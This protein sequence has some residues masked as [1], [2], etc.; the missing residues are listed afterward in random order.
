M[1]VLAVYQSRHF[2]WY[3]CRE[4]HGA[5]IGTRGHIQNWRDVNTDAIYKQGSKPQAAKGRSS[6][7]CGENYEESQLRGA[8]LFLRGDLEG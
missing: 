7:E 5:R 4:T 3:V 8:M 6:P 1:Q 2:S